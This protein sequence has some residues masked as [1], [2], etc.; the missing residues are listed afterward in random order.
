VGLH[1]ACTSGDRHLFTLLTLLS[2][3]VALF[4]IGLL[5]AERWW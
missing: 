5:G 3:P 4:G 2:L 1:A